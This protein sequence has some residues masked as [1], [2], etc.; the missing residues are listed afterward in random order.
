[1]E[2]FEH[3]IIIPGAISATER[4]GHRFAMP[5]PP[6]SHTNLRPTGSVIQV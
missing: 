3:D 2:L 5:L 1:M 4:M 6:A